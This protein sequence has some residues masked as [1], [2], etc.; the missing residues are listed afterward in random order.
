[1]LRTGLVKHISRMPNQ[2]TSK[3]NAIRLLLTRPAASQRSLLRELTAAGCPEHDCGNR[4][5]VPFTVGRV[6]TANRT[7]DLLPGGMCL[8][9]TPDLQARKTSPPTRL[10]HR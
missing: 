5:D 9:S 4:G 7:R 8:S 1:M 6:P 10:T 2:T 3:P